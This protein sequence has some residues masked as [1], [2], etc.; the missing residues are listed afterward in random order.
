MASTSV[1]R[2]IPASP[3]KVWDLIG[4][5]GSLPDWLPYIP[6]STFGSPTSRRAPCRRA[7]GSVGWRTRTA[8]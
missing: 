6:K 5:F 1:S 8:T 3:Q 2:T 7:V 4:G